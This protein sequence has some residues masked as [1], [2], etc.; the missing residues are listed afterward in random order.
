MRIFPYYLYHICR[1]KDKYDFSKGYIGVSKHPKKRWSSGGYRANPHLM[2]ALKKYPDIIKYVVKVGTKKECLDA[3]RRLRPKENTA[4]NIARGGGV[5][6]SPKGLP[7][8]VSNLPK[9]KRRKN[10]KPSEEAKKKMSESQRKRSKEIS[11]QN[12]GE[13]N[14][15]FGVCGRDHPSWKGWYITPLACFENVEEVCRFYNISKPAVMRRC[16][17]GGIIKRSRWTSKELHGKT[18]KEVGWSFKEKEK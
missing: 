3:E 9:E 13:K 17:I 11:I 12:S 7:H 1:E 14:G 4:W 16:K 18:W 10:Y 5:A 6:P 2:N 15:M 8:C